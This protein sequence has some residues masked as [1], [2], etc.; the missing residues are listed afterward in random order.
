MISHLLFNNCFGSGH[1][2]YLCSQWAPMIQ[3]M[4]FMFHWSIYGL[5]VLNMFLKHDSL[6]MI[7]FVYVCSTRS[8]VQLKTVFETWIARNNA[9]GVYWSH[10]SYLITVMAL[11]IRLKC[12]H[13]GRQ[14]SK[15]C[16]VCLIVQ[17]T[18]YLY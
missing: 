4:Y 12:A 15:S 5:F 11:D 3:I 16:I 17:N 9:I 14:M 13:N 2:A 1:E 7:I 8:L 6:E 10:L 18:D